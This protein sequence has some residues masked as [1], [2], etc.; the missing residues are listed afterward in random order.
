MTTERRTRR[1]WWVLLLL[2][3]MASVLLSSAPWHAALRSF[4]TLRAA[5]QG[6]NLRI[7]AID[8]GLF[9]ATELYDVHCTQ[10][11]VANAPLPGGTDFHIE[12]AELV[13]AWG[14]PWQQRR[15]KT[16]L[17]RVSLDGLSGTCDF[18]RPP[19]S[20]PMRPLR[21]VL[22]HDGW[23]P[24]AEALARRAIHHGSQSL[25]RQLQRLDH[26]LLPG[27]LDVRGDGCNLQRGRYRLHAEGMR[28]MIS[29]DEVGHFA[30]RLAQARGP[31]F[32]SVLHGVA[33]WTYW[34]GSSLQAG[35]VDLGSGV[36][37]ASATLEGE[38]LD[39][40]QLD[41]EGELRAL[42]GS[43]RGQGALDLSRPRLALEI[44][45]SLE[46]MEVGPLAR[47]LGVR[48]QTG[49]EVQQANFTFRGDPENWTAAEMWLS[50]QATDF[51]WEQ[52]R[53]ESLQIQGV[54]IHRR[55]QV[56]RL[57]LRQSRNQLSFSGECALPAAAEGATALPALTATSWW[58]AGFSCNIDARIDDLHAFA[59][60]AGGEL[61]ELQGRMSVNGALHANPGSSGIDGYL[62][63]EGSA[64]SIRGAPLESLRTTL[65]FAGDELNIPDLE[66][67][68]GGD[69][70]RGQG[71]LQITGP[72]RYKAELHAA[73]KDL[74]VYAPAYADLAFTPQP[75]N[76]ALTLDWSGDGTPTANSGAF[77]AVLKHFFTKGGPAAL[78]RPI[79]LAGDGTYSPDSVSF[80]HL[81][82][83]EGTDGKRHDALKLEGALPWTRDPR[84]FAAGRWLDPDRPMSVRVAGVGAPLDLLAS[85]APEFVSRADGQI[86]GW[87]NADGTLRSPKLE[88]DL[89]LENASFQP[90]G[91]APAI[92]QVEARL[93]LERSVLHLAQAAGR[94]GAQMLEASGEMDL[95]DTDHIGLDLKVQGK[96]AGGIHDGALNAGL[97]YD[98]SVRLPQRD[99]ANIAGEIS[100]LDGRYE[101]PLRIGYDEF[102]S[103]EW[104]Q[105]G[106]RLPFAW[107]GARVEL[108][109]GATPAIRLTGGGPEAELTPDLRF[110]GT[111][112][113]VRVA[114][115]VAFQQAPL[116]APGG[117]RGVGDGAWYFG[118]GEP[119][120]PMVSAAARERDGTQVFFCGAAAA[121]MMVPEPVRAEESEPWAEPNALA[122]FGEPR[123]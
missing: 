79:D 96:D 112:P 3:S 52:R 89:H 10:R 16:W 46:K 108:H 65:L 28:L 2:A 1:W 102:A 4:L 31:G 98:L 33:G 44:A 118:G 11:R 35:G 119:G 47:L 12:R 117:W 95:T 99:G 24:A 90:L 82:L 5:H 20:E 81:V 94:W 122:A 103:L 110:T 76:G 8:G 41:W 22:M 77:Q 48:G 114:G 83:Q 62:N 84:A 100:L 37:L 6:W 14:W 39:R 51:Q 120:E 73:I 49:G 67:T 109:L 15:G 116:S 93:T 23:G 13:V 91:G 85:L 88:A 66:A 19:A 107:A 27:H 123:L 72:A 55:V 7:G 25:G 74:A 106:D 75:I 60:L 111:F 113:A 64:L 97:S 121:G 30:A 50:A 53:W 71:T 69:Y 63:V 61:P 78:A 58:Q 43:A 80:R 56:H 21:Q 57:E 54:V 26:A 105:L 101:E 9:D 59:E 86:S 29:Q 38:H 40:G 68:R 42:G 32:D 87:L 36:H 17:G 45:G 18:N 104:L 115:E 92:D 70:F 34:K